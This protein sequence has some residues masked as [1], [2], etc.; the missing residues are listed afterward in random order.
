MY[1]T[2]RTMRICVMETSSL[3]SHS[4]YSMYV[5]MRR[6]CNVWVYSFHFDTSIAVIQL[7]WIVCSNSLLSSATRQTY[8]MSENIY[9]MLWLSLLCRNSQTTCTNRTMRM[10]VMEISS[11]ITHSSNI[12]YVWIHMWFCYRFY[13][14]WIHRCIAQFELWSIKWWKS[15]LSS[16]TRR[17]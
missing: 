16:L 14:I 10:C 12:I 9:V 4:S 5:W 8:C 1:C 13:W 6:W 11:L 2:N 17:T 15:S 7:W 3:I